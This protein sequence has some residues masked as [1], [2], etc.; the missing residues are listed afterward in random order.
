MPLR[1]D[2][3]PKPLGVCTVCRD[4]T[5][6]HIRMNHRGVQAHRGRRCSG[7]YRSSLTVVWIECPTCHG[8][9]SVGSQ[10][11]GE[12]AGWGWLLHSMR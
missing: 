8:T 3:K 10:K 2:K 4:Y 12:C 5:D 1:R 7:V 9:G 11:C 6:E